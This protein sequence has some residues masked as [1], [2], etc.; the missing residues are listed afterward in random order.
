MKNSSSQSVSPFSAI[1]SLLLMAVAFFIIEVIILQYVWNNVMPQV[2]P[3][4]KELNIMHS[5]LLIILV[6]ILFPHST[7]INT[8]KNKL[9]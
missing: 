9:F 6:N 1:L 5:I 2:F 8:C 7:Y 4:V 3:S